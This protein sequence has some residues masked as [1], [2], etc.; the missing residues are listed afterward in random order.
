MKLF[1]ARHGEYQNPDGLIPYRLPG[2]PLTDL[3]IEQAGLQATKLAQFKIRDIFTS[4]VERCMQTASIIGKTLS[5]APNPIEAL[6]ELGSPLQGMT[7]VERDKYRGDFPYDLQSHIDGGGETKHD[8]FE[9]MSNFIEK[10]KLMSKNS[11][12]LIVSHGDPI[13]FYLNNVLKRDVR[14]IP[15]GGLVIL[16]YSQSGTPKYTELV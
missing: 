7:I 3:G 10:L 2:F 6:I 8:V 13:K 15:M 1:L 16:D 11:S 14:Y 5:L 4:P 9:R 12:H